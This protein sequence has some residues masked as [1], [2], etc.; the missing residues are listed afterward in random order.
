MAKPIKAVLPALPD[1]P[2]T[3]FALEDSV[4]IG[5]A[6]LRRLASIYPDFPK[7][8]FK[9]GPPHMCRVYYDP[10]A[11]ADFVDELIRRGEVRGMHSVPRRAKGVK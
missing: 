2:E 1:H 6:R 4:G 11:V 3:F 10:Q 8:V 9:A 5:A 7:P